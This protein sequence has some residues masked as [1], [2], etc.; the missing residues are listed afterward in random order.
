MNASCFTNKRNF[1]KTIIKVILI[2]SFLF[3]GNH[4]LV[5]AV[6]NTGSKCG[7]SEA[8]TILDKYSGDR[9]IFKQASECLENM[10]ANDPLASLVKGRI[11]VKNGF[12][13]N[14]EF[15]KKAMAEATK[16]YEQ[17]IDLAPEDYEVNSIQPC[18][19]AM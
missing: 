12:S 8:M 14:D 11:L 7:F 18:F 9:D 6:E 3:F 2:S 19:T 5:N 1:M 4:T 16:Y 17:A 13:K 10:G 15:S